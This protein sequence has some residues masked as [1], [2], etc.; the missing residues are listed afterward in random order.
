M[1]TSEDFYLSQVVGLWEALNA[2]VTSL[3]DHSHNINTQQVAEAALAAYSDSGARV[4]FGYGFDPTG[5][6]TIPERAAHV[7]ELATDQR[8]STGLVQMG[9]EFDTWTG[10]D[11]SDL[12]AVLGLLKDGNLSVLTTH[13]PWI[14]AIASSD[15]IQ[16]LD[17]TLRG[18]PDVSDFVRTQLEALEEEGLIA[19]LERETVKFVQADV[20]RAYGVLGRLGRFEVFVDGL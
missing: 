8:L 19:N 9:M 17:L 7:L 6:F 13:W 14:E 15:V 12:E 20:D 18:A 3:L 4:W 10:V 5:N 11:K 1:F 2:G 16:G